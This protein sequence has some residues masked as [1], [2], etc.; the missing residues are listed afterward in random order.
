MNGLEEERKPTNYECWYHLIEALEMMKTA[1]PEERS[2][3]ARR[4][5]V[6]ITEMEKITA[7]FKV[8]ILDGQPE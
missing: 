8:F 5:A 6:S 7:Y 1:K 3:L 4:Y 2:E